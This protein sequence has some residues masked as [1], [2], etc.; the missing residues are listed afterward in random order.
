[1]T[2]KNS[3]QKNKQQERLSSPLTT[4]KIKKQNTKQTVNIPP[5]RQTS[6]NPELE[7]TIEVDPLPSKKGK[8][9]EML[10]VTPDKT[11]ILDVNAS[12]DVLI[13]LIEIPLDSTEYCIKTKF[14]KFGKIVYFTIETKNM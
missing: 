8:A 11:T 2:R 14:T 1:M 6:E 9:K 3:E 10:E 4:Q 12:F 13:R 5:T 7:V